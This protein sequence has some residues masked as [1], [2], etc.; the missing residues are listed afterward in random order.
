[1]DRDGSMTLLILDFDGT[2][3]DLPVDYAGLRAALGLR[4]EDSLG[5]SYQRYLDEGDEQRLATVTRFELDAVEHGRLMPGAADLLDRAGPTAV[6]TRNSR[7]AVVAALGELV[8]HVLVVGREDVPRL[9]PAPDGL[10]SALNHFSCPPEDAVVIGDTSH[11]VEAGR[12]LGVR[13]VVVE[14][15]RVRTRPLGADHYVASLADERIVNL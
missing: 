15:P 2:L 11:D 4:P 13:T 10:S 8:Q 5:E 3:Y 14:N 9:K 6:V 1:M 7:L 12:A